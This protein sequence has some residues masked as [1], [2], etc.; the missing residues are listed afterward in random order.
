MNEIDLELKQELEVN[1]TL[2]FVNAL[3][4]GDFSNAESMFKDI[5]GDKVQ[6]TL[7]AE[8]VSVAD[9]IFNGVEAEDLE[10]TDG[11]IEAELLAALES[12]ESES[13]IE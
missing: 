10:V 9:Q 2:D 13:D 5:L 8:K 11:E 6:D 12:E 3:Q 1:P 4:V 7:N